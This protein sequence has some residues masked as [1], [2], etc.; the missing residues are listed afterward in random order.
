MAIDT[1]T[2]SRSYMTKQVTSLSKMMVEKTTQLASEKSST[3]FGGL[4]N[5]RLLDLELTQRV[6]QIDAY[7]E[8]IIQANLHMETLNLTLERLEDLRIDAKAA[9]NSNDFVLQSDGQTR[10]QETAK[11][12]LHEA[13]NLLNTE[14]AGYYLYG[15]KDAFTDPVAAVEDILEGAGGKDG[16]KQVMNEFYQANLGANNNGRLDVSALTT[17][18]TLGVPTDSTFTIA[19]DGAH[20]FGFDI[21][22]VTSGLSNVAI[23]GPTGTDPDSFDV[24]FTG[25][26]VLGDEISFEFTLPPGHT[27]TF[28]LDLKAT[29]EGGEGAFAIGADLAETAEN[30]RVKISEELEKEAQTSLKAISDEWAA[31]NF[32]DTFGGAEPMRVDGPPFDTSTTLISG[33]ATTVAWY[34][35]ENSPTTDARNDKSAIVD[36]N[37]EVNYGARANENGLK[38]IVKSLATFISADFSAATDN[39]KLY[40]SSS[41]AS[42]RAILQPEGAD[43]S[44]IVDITTDV[45]IAYRAVKNSDDRHDQM[46][47]SYLTTVDEIEGVDKELLAAEIL[48]LQTNIEASYRASSIVYN[49][50]IVDYL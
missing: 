11:V 21:S 10:S 41:A 24:Q 20:D 34:V 42:M 31:D 29:S 36:N 50:S 28:K 46:R 2:T 13:V 15:G 27:E 6:G 40:Y 5:N 18:L 25:Q 32:F 17:N 14:V 19:E 1:I 48:Q 4:G 35:G 8:T 37:L 33:A 43:Q 49:L 39:D 9:I 3:T 44:G 23:T 30:L 12:L 26:P 47:S 45:A 16:L 7:K 22:S 38:D